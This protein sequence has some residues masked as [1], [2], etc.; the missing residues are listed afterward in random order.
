MNESD[1][2]DGEALES[3]SSE[4]AHLLERHLF[5]GLVL[6]VKGGAA[7]TVV[8][9]H[10]VEDDD[11]AVFGTLAGRD[12]VVG[13]EALAGD[14]DQRLG[15]PAADRRQQADF[16]VV[17]EFG[18]RRGKLLIHSDSDGG[19]QRLQAWVHTLISLE[20]VGDAGVLGK[21]DGVG[22]AAEDIL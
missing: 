11:G 13:A 8:A 6:E 2:A 7:A 20:Q 10:P 18:G 22:G 4:F 14:L 19:K 3:L 16:V 9:D 15:R 21:R 5:I 1:I 12:E 17:G